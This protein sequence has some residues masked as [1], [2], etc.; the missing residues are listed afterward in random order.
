MVKLLDVE[1]VYVFALLPARKPT[2]RKDDQTKAAP[3]ESSQPEPG[4]L[5]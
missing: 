5:L 3:D 2:L 1:R 4:W